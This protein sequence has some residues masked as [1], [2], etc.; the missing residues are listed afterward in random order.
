[1]SELNTKNPVEKKSNNKI[2]R[3]LLGWVRDIGIALL[4]VF[5]IL[6]F[7]GQKTNVV[8][9]SME[10]TLHDGDRLIVDKLSY[11]FN[12]V[13]RYDIIVFP[14]APKLYYIKRVIGL[15]GDTVTIEDGFVWVNGEKLDKQYQF[16]T[17]HQYGNNLPMKVPPGEYFVLGDNRNNSSDSRYID[18]GTIK[19]EEIMGLARWRFWPINDVGTLE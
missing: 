4:V 3:E 15:P 11:R 19:R 5:L 13:E 16:E 18:V 2:I 7:L 12:E 9:K 1:M 17:I 10:P 8:G 14:H 6:T